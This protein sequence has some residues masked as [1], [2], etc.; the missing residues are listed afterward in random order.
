MS[1]Q[2]LDAE[3]LIDWDGYLLFD[4]NQPFGFELE[5]GSQI[6]GRCDFFFRGSLAK[7][8]F[9]LVRL[10]LALPPP[11]DQD[12]ATPLSLSCAFH[13]CMASI[14]SLE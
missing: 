8:A 12:G 3:Q 14:I 5:E 1:L 4:G 9:A 10:E 13:H 11:Q 6:S 2:P 7:R